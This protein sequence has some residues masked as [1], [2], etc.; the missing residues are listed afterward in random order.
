LFQF[1]AFASDI[2]NVTV[3]ACA[4]WSA[5]LRANWMWLV[6]SAITAFALTEFFVFTIANFWFDWHFCVIWWISEHLN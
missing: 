6:T 3:F 2:A 5:D 4:T 1:H